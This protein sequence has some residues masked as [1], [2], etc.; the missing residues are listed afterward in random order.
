MS[1]NDGGVRLAGGDTAN[2]GRVEVCY[3]RVWGSVCD[4]YWSNINAA[5]VCQQLDFQGSSMYAC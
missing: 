3:D 5:I 2:E 4:S 1:C